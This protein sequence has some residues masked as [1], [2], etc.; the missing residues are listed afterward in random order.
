MKTLEER[1]NLAAW[2]EPGCGADDTAIRCTLDDLK[3]ALV[4]VSMAVV[5][6]LP[7]T[8]ALREVADTLALAIATISEIEEENRK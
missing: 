8:D 3:S 2:L 5:D 6:A 4:S 1:P 7:N